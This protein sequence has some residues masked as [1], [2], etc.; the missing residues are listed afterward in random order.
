METYSIWETS[1][2]WDWSPFELK[3]MKCLLRTSPSREVALSDAPPVII[4]TDA[5]DVPGR[6]PQQVIG[7]VLF[8]PLRGVIFYTSA[9]VSAD[10][11]DSWT[12]RK[13][14]MGQ[15]ELLATVLPLST[16]PELVRS[17]H[18]LL[19]VDNDSA[20]SGLV[21]GYSPQLDSGA[22][23]GQFWLSAADCKI[24]VYVDRVES[25]RLEFSLMHEWGAHWT[26]PNFDLLVSPKIHPDHWFGT[27][28][29]CR[30]GGYQWQ[31]QPGESV[32]YPSLRWAHHNIDRP[33]ARG[34]R[35]ETCYVVW[36]V[37][38]VSPTEKTLQQFSE[39]SACGGIGVYP[40]FNMP[41]SSS[42]G[43]K[44]DEIQATMIRYIRRNSLCVP[45]RLYLCG[46]LHSW[47]RVPSRREMDW[48]ITEMVF[49][50]GMDRSSKREP[51]SIKAPMKYSSES[52]MSSW[53]L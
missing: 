38:D 15:L 8:D 50:D 19:F 18:I 39:K 6:I 33:S 31:V 27:T 22:I 3:L 42:I 46:T 26:T 16:W 41:T 7:A 23:I 5:S 53:K 37:P 11:I 13:S 40:L 35:C 44:T 48:T 12:S 51:A 45:W 36:A 10:L 28:S 2:C 47:S 32:R 49:F 34:T 14:Y 9:E 21:K 20:A 25:R 43:T 24:N 29:H 30:G 4:Y 52:W 17:K 1:V